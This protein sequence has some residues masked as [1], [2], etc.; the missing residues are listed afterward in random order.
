[1]FCTFILKLIPRWIVKLGRLHRV[2][3]INHRDGWKYDRMPSSQLREV[4]L[5]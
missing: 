1:M 2:T 5:L 4:R 3:G